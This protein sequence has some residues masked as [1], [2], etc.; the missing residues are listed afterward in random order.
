MS[1]IYNNGTGQWQDTGGGQGSQQSADDLQKQIMAQTG[2]PMPA[3]IGDEMRQHLLSQQAGLAGQFADQGQKGFAQYGQQAQGAL[4]ALQR[5]ANGQ[6][7]V[8]AEQLRQALGQQLSQQRSF[9]AGASPHNAAGAA[10]TAAI[11]MG[12]A[13]TA[14]A[15]QQATAG[16]AERN[17][18]QSQYGSMLQGMSSQQL[19]AALSGRQNALGGYGAGAY[20]GN[21]PSVVTQAIPAVAAAFAAAASDRALKTNIA[22]GD[23]A[24]NA[25]MGALPSSSSASPNATGLDS[26]Y[27]QIAAAPVVP[28]VRWG[29]A[30]T[31]GS[32]FAP[33]PTPDPSAPAGPSWLQRFAAGAAA[34]LGAPRAYS[35]RLLKRD[36]KPGDDKANAA[37]DGLR[38][39]T[40]AYKDPALG[41]GP[42]V[43]VMAQDLQAAGLGQA[44]V[45]TPIGLAIDPGK[46]SGAN[47]A[48][49]AALGRRVAE[50][51]GGGS[52]A[53]TSPAANR[54]ALLARKDREDPAAGGA[55]DALDSRRAKLQELDLRTA[56]A[57][58]GGF[59]PLG[60]STGT[61]AQNDLD[62]RRAVMAAL[63]R[64][65]QIAQAGE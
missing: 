17:A 6:N 13:S 36:I 38:P 23:A 3:G 14:M 26:F 64:R 30:S 20:G 35:D 5:Q 31:P 29:F 2:Q 24:A 56:G 54:A 19:Q 15:G 58:P 21:Q 37:I 42:Q 25:A 18:A 53:P 48:M 46:L 44:V 52:G 33:A 57:Y 4:D 16:L 32:S 40:Y 49:I 59:R 63:A 62:R 61:A 10:R 47:T 43:G 39:Y 60:D 41:A 28:P 8:S 65:S 22:P 51:E 11:Q 34:G 1:L 27:N 12:R 7:S 9:A 50:L 45:R 55:Q